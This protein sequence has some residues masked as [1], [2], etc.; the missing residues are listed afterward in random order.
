MAFNYDV[1]G[2]VLKKKDISEIKVFKLID[3]GKILNELD[4]PGK[5]IYLATYSINSRVGKIFENK[6]SKIRVLYDKRGENEVEVNK[7]A[8]K[9]PM[10]EFYPVKRL[11]L[12]L[13]LVEPDIVIV[14]TANLDK[15]RNEFDVGIGF[16][17]RKACWVY[18]K[19]LNLLMAIRFI[20]AGIRFWLEENPTFS[21]HK[22]ERFWVEDEYSKVFTGKEIDIEDIKLF[23][24]TGH[25]WHM[26]LPMGGTVK[27]DEEWR[28]L[29]IL[30]YTMNIF[31]EDIL[32][33]VYRRRCYKKVR[34]VILVCNGRVN[35]NI[36]LIKGLK[37]RFPNDGFFKFLVHDNLHAKLVCFERDTVYVSTQN[38]IQIGSSKEDEDTVVGV[39]SEKICR[40]YYENF[41]KR[42]V[43]E[44]KEV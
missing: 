24:S 9:F 19:Y 34:N 36:E 3:W 28:N 41:V 6:Q 26:K 31:V 8:K 11:H 40:W 5:E 33:H 39:H 2:P 42:I 1:F 16:R 44:A 21:E 35:G 23:I 38:F 25:T 27:L 12:K 17:S 29:Y 20:V 30:T 13:V 37:E 10:I 22:N 4:C 43:S 32:A 15:I 14:P 18:S 7:L